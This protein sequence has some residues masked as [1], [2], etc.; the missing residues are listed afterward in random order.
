VAFLTSGQ[1]EEAI[2]EFERALQ[3]KPNYLSPR[4]N[5]D[6]ALANRKPPQ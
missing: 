5:L 4:R 2:P 1:A 3:L 6:L